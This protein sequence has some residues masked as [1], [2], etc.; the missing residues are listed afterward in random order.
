MIAE[1][2]GDTVFADVFERLSHIVNPGG[3]V[4]QGIC[5]EL[6]YCP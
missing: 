6:G 3:M 4:A 2:L 5:E 1:N